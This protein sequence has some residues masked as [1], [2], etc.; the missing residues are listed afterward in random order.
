MDAGTRQKRVE[1]LETIKNKALERA[2]RGD[3]S[4]EVRDFVTSAKKELAYEL[5]DT[6]AFQKAMNATLAYKAKKG[7]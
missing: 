4:L 6:E 1:A 5:P 3:D 2:Q 7:Q